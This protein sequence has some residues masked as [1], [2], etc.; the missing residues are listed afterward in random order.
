[1]NN[2]RSIVM[3]QNVTYILSESFDYDRMI[4][5]DAGTKYAERQKWVTAPLSA[6]GDLTANGPVII[7]QR[8]TAE[9]L[10]ALV[11]LIWKLPSDRILYFKIVDPY[12]E[13][14]QQPY[15]QLLLYLTR[16]RNIRFIGPYHEVGIIGVLSGLAERSVYLHV[17][18]AYE[19]DKEVALNPEKRGKRL[20]F[21]GAADPTYYPERAAVLRILQRKWFSWGR[22][23]ILPHP[24]YPDVGHRQRHTVIGSKYIDFLASHWFMYLEPSR[25]QLEFLKYS[26]CAYAGCVPIGRSPASFDPEL[27]SLILKMESATLKEDMT[28]SMV[29]SPHRLREHAQKYRDLLRARRDPDQLN[30]RLHEH[31]Q[32]QVHA[33]R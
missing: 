3:S 21:S 22:V 18:Y 4:H 24:G 13:C 19:P 27:A 32:S 9:E 11:E 14:I 20:A 17:P 29:L 26:E 6:V 25:D 28:R 23:S 31:W 7:D 12:W 8:L 15:Y 30:E 16:F 1:M 33:V 5:A 2:N 10:N